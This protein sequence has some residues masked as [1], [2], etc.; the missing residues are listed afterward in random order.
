M[1][2]YNLLDMTGAD[3]NLFLWYDTNTNVFSMVKGSPRIVTTKI[4]MGEQLYTSL[5]QNTEENMK[6]TYLQLFQFLQDDSLTSSSGFR[7]LSSIATDRG[8]NVDIVGEQYFGIRS[9]LF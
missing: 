7:R 4:D 3:P 5:D 9:L 1:F 2:R 8:S 6:Q